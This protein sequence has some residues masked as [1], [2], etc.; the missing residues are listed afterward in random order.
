MNDLIKEAI[1]NYCEG[2][3]HLEFSIDD[4]DKMVKDIKDVFETEVNDCEHIDELKRLF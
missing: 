4:I 3:N 2:I 1:F